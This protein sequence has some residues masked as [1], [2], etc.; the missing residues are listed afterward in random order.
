MTELSKSLFDS[1]PTDGFD[2]IDVYQSGALDAISAALT[3]TNGQVTVDNKKTVVN[4]IK[5]IASNPKQEISLEKVNSLGLGSE[6][7]KRVGP[8]VLPSWINVSDLIGIFENCGIFNTR[9]QLGYDNK[10]GFNGRL[11]NID[12][13]FGFNE[14]TQMAAIVAKKAN[15]HVGKPLGAMSEE[16]IFTYMDATRKVVIGMDKGQLGSS[17]EI[18]RMGI[19]TTDTRAQ[20][21]N[22]L[23]T[24]NSPLAE[25]AIALSFDLG[26]TVLDTQSENS[27]L[28]DTINNSGYSDREKHL[29]RRELAGMSAKK[30]DLSLTAGLV[31]DMDTAASGTFRKEMARIGTREYVRPATLSPVNYPT[32]G[33]KLKTD[34]ETIYP[35]AFK[36]NGKSHAEILNHASDDALSMLAFN[37]GMYANCQAILHSQRKF[38]TAVEQIQ[39][40]RPD[41][42]VS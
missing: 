5:A 4:A 12:C 3:A 33:A 17:D 21:L 20:T 42:M 9:D 16:E 38:T 41:F 36:R 7:L 40:E 14:F 22:K 34:V 27:E 35:T 2:V 32:E 28:R 15:D 30:G 26:K 39:Q 8:S 6:V 23:L 37:D 31:T 19:A 11:Q 25:K 29:W 13:K 1:G 18:R 10:R 24:S